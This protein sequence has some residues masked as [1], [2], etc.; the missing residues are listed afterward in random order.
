MVSAVF[1]PFAEGERDTVSS[2]SR[3]A[4]WA[5]AQLEFNCTVSLT[6]VY[7]LCRVVPFAAAHGT[8]YLAIHCVATLLAH[9]LRGFAY[10]SFH[11]SLCSTMLIRFADSHSTQYLA[12]HCVA[13]LLAHLQFNCGGV[14]WEKYEQILRGGG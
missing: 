13:T 9:P 10:Y 3:F 5:C 2:A 8:Q 4:L 6:C 11:S 1:V 12:I 7:P 14:R